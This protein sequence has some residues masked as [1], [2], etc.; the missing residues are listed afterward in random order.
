[1][2]S[3]AAHFAS[4]GHVAP[5]KVNIADMV[6]DLVIR[7]PAAQV[8]RL[9]AAYEASP[10]AAADADWL[11]K[12]TMSDALHTIA[13]YAPGHALPRLSTGQALGYA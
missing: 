4:L 2:S 7:S 5:P 9:A 12:I 11:A 3:A 6:L 13:Q 1:M 10:V 8:E